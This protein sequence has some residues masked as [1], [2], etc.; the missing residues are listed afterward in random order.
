LSRFGVGTGSISSATSTVTYTYTP[1]G[2]PEPGTLSVGAFVL[3]GMIVQA[4]AGRKGR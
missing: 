1:S 2:A 4:R 3:C